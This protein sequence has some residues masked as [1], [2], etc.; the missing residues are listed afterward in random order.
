[1]GGSFGVFENMLDD[2][3]EI[4]IGQ[5]LMGIIVEEYGFGV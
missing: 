5:S 2:F 4:F 1:M 3:V